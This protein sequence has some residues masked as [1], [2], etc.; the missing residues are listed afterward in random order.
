MN[1]TYEQME[2]RT[3]YILRQVK[4]LIEQG[5]NTFY[6]PEWRPKIDEVDILGVIVAKYCHWETKKILK[7]VSSALEDANMHTLSA[8]IDDLVKAKQPT[9]KNEV[10]TMGKLETKDGKLVID[11]KEVVK[12]WES[13]SGGYW[14]AVDKNH[15]Q[16]SLINGKEVKDVI[17]FGY[18]QGLSDE[19]GY[20][21]EAEIDSLK[22][23]TW[24][25]QPQDLPYAGRRR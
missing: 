6:T 17:W 23:K 19:W 25:I 9:P 3:N 14:F 12:G 7:V 13:Y 21:S 5:R 10:Q 8:Q 11:G 16:I 1:L 20:F 4:H 18:V 15:E 24:E 22:P 2:R